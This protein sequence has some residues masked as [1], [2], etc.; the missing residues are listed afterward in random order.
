MLI[1]PNS[2]PKIFRDKGKK[3]KWI[4]GFLITFSDEVQ[5]LF[6]DGYFYL[7]VWLICLYLCTCAGTIVTAGVIGDNL[8]CP[9]TRNRGLAPSF[10]FFFP[11]KICSTS[12]FSHRIYSA[13]NITS[14]VTFPTVFHPGDPCCGCLSWPFRMRGWFL[15]GAV[16]ACPRMEEWQAE[17]VTHGENIFQVQEMRRQN[18][19][20]FQSY[21]SR[22]LWMRGGW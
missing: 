15:A 12:K 14:Q 1:F 3:E 18:I 17:I 5:Q 13:H 6:W 4:L 19:N 16:P 8:N 11:F 7:A 9:G 22:G 20:L 2:W 10:F 21:L